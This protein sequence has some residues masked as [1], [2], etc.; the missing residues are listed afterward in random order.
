MSDGL[1][2]DTVVFDFTG[3]D[4]D[5]MVA[6]CETDELMPFVRSLV[7]AAG[8]ILEAGAGS[9]RWV[10]ALTSLGY[11][12]TGIELSAA[13]VERFRAAWPDIP[14]DHGNVEAMPYADGAFD[15][16]L[17][18]GVIEHL[19]QGPEKAIAEMRRVLKPD[20]VMFLTVPHGNLSFRLEQVKD[21]IFYR[22]YG[23]NRVR[24]LMGRPPVS[25]P[26]AVERQRMEAIRRG[27]RPGVAVKYRFDPRSGVGFYEYRY[28][29]AQIRHL[30]ERG[31]F[32]IE[33]F[34][35]LNA[36]DRL[37]Q[38][39]GTLVARYD[40]SSQPRLNVLGRLLVRLLPA[41]WIG[42]MA[43]LIARPAQA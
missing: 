39:F 43:L 10:R 13:D 19:F 35:L 37:Y 32:R 31:G 29:T 4:L 38:I 36:P 11:A 34:H 3:Q 12:A 9:G 40:G 8:S 17:S 16:L 21:A 26:V 28:D 18:L 33:A 27:R 5:S 15:A 14:Y 7:P 2:S 30:I 23:S 41:G 25:Y 42:H 20:G 22:L 24:R 1:I 6:S